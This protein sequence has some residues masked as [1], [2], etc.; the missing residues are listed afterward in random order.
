MKSPV[1]TLALAAFGLAVSAAPAQAQATRKCST[2]TA[3]EI[4]TLETT[5]SAKIPDLTTEKLRAF[6]IDNSSGKKLLRFGNGILNAGGGPFQVR[7][8]TA[9]GITKGIQQILN[10]YSTGSAGAQVVFECESS[11][12]AYHPEHDHWH[13]DA[14]A[15]YRLYSATT[16]LPYAAR[17]A[18]KVS[19]CLIDYFRVYPNAPVRR[20]NACNNGVQGISVGWSDYYSSTLPDQYLDVTGLPNGRY[21]V[22]SKTNANGSFLEKSK[23]NNVMWAL[24]QITG[25]TVSVVW[26]GT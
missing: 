9:G 1:L 22:Y 3:A 17:D 10:T 2:V 20:F 14:V 19:F 23:T 5:K 4:A 26:Q 15:R 24:V 8:V 21:W 25:N 16:G 11:A 7:P 6:W 18:E 12:Y 13:M